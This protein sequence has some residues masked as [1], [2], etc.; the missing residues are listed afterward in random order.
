MY[1]TSYLDYRIVLPKEFGC[2][3]TLGHPKFL[4]FLYSLYIIVWGRGRAIDQPERAVF[5]LDNC[6]YACLSVSIRECLFA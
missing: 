4:Y 1:D 3:M 2:P 6:V 5:L